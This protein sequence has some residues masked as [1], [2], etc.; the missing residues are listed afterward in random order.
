MFLPICERFWP[1]SLS[2]KQIEDNKDMLSKYDKCDTED[3]GYYQ[4]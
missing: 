4:V 1:N 3:E 2:E